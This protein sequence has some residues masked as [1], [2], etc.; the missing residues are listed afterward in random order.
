M[1]LPAACE[2]RVSVLSWK[3][4][5][6]WM[7]KPQPLI[8]YIAVQATATAAHMHISSCLPER[9]K[10]IEY[11]PSW[12]GNYSCISAAFCLV[13]HCFFKDIWYQRM[14]MSEGFSPGWGIGAHHWPS[15]CWVNL[16]SRHAT[17][18]GYNS[19]KRFCDKAHFSR[20]TQQPC[21]VPRCH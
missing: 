8:G 21:W 14:L 12:L 16:I 11:I 5:S 18:A 6:T 19:G 17:A 10:H 2:H 7:T 4:H 15:E 20:V 13:R 9:L 1:P 3:K